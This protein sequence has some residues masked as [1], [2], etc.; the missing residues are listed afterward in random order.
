MRIEVHRHLP[1][2]LKEP[3]WRVYSDAF[4]ELRAQAVQRHVMYRHEFDDL[5]RDDRVFKYLGWRATD[6]DRL[7]S[8]ATITNDLDAVPLISPDFFR[9]RWPA[10]Y[11]ERRIWYVTFNAIRPEDRGSGLFERVIEE[12]H[13]TVAPHNPS[14]V[15]LDFCGR[16][17]DPFKLPL[18]VHR[19]LAGLDTVKSQR[20][21]VQAYWCY[22][23]LDS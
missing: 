16:N 14:V 13:R 3:A 20:V 15:G 7:A 19:V 1:D 18:A 11:E 2:H 22:E 6:D 8:L 9:H 17:E 21:D 12:M 10:H 4:D 23:L 5:M